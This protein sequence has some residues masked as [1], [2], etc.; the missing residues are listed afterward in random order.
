[1]R[2]SSLF[3][4]SFAIVALSL[5]TLI[6]FQRLAGPVSA[7][8][9]PAASTADTGMNVTVSLSKPGNGGFLVAGETAEVTVTLRDKF[10]GPLSRDDFATLSLYMYG[11]QETTKTVTAKML[12]ASMDRSQRPHHYIDL[13]TNTSVRVDGNALKYTLQP[14]TDEEP[15]TY[16]A[17]VRAVKKGDPPVNQ[18]FVLADF[19]VGTATVENQIV[20]AENCAA[21][22]KG[23]DSGQFYLHHV[24]PSGSNAYGSPSID[25]IPVRTCKA[26]HNNN[27]YAAYAG[28]VDDPTADPSKVRT[29]D[30][31]VRRVHGVHM[32]EELKNP[33]NNDPK[34]GNFR[35]YIGVIFPANVKN[36]STCHVDDRWKTQP[37]RQACGACHDN[38]WFGDAAAAPEKWEAHP[39]GPQAN[40]AAC[41][42]CHPAD[43]GGAMPVS[44]AHKVVQLLNDVEVSMT[45]PGNGKFY[46]AGEAPVVTIVIKDDDGSSLDHTQVKVANFSTAG[47]FVYGNR[48]KTVPVLT[49]TAKYGTSKLRASVSNST[50]AAGSPTRG[51]T[52]A[53]GDTF[54]IA[55]NG[56]APVELAAPVGL[57][58]PAQVRDWLSSRLSGVT[59]TST[60]TNVSI[61]SNI[62]GE[63]SRIDIYNSAVTTIMGWK[64]GGVPYSGGTTP[65]VT[66]EPYVNPGRASYPT[67]DLRELSDPLDY[68]DPNVIRNVENITYQLD[69]VAGLPP[70]TYMV[71]VWIQPIA[72]RNANVSRP[73][74][75]FINFQ[76]GTEKEE[77][78][79]ATNCKDCHGNSI[80]HLDEGPQHPEPFDP[81]YCKACHDY[82][83]YNTGDGFDRLGGTSQNGWS[84]YGAVPI[85]RRVHGVH[86][87]RYL[88]HPE[89]IY[90][91][92]P[93]AFNEVIFPQDVRN[94][95]K[96]HDPQGSPAWKEQPS[97]LAC[98]ACHDSNAANS[99]AK[100][101]TEYPTP[102]DS[103]SDDRVETCTIC[104]GAGRELSPD[105]VHNI[106]NPYKPPYPREPER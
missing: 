69:D 85:S 62:Q 1:M 9:P 17:A 53:A 105:K 78:K 8:T 96:C 19:Q 95:T 60:A 45:P 18:A 87:G 67:N 34:T 10:G 32:G 50:A 52:F 81:D 20:A 68:S 21:C 2:R 76:V 83:R 106:S 94:C 63:N 102:S 46:V 11:P 79:V 40:D 6:G 103:W 25:S 70:G 39:G 99:H 86:F 92:N 48:A 51:W 15:G 104:H 56:G 72:G 97:R 71:Y 73:A 13:L 29:P 28:N 54:K 3:L 44:E 26:C 74:I 55:V 75:G 49:N 12:N 64:R 33:F 38:V 65:G 42:Q 36:C 31:I 98:M 84:G 93:D 100:L 66:V 91:G 14:V 4:V 101:M 59:V 43:T 41:A 23:A 82:G 27:G 37:S 61:K 89:Q 58:T 24:D 88:E 47:L 77:P 16:T 35:D 22:H 80:W 90:A 5:V 7:Q 30:P 57:Q